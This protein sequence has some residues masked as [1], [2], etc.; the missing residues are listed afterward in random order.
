M[1]WFYNG[2]FQ[3]CWEVIKND[4]MEV[5]FGFFNSGI[6]NAYTNA[7]FICLISKKERSLN[8]K[9]FRPIGLVTSLYKIEWCA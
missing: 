5:F 1:G 7:S 6:V 2:S 9:H 3:D 4:L 8:F